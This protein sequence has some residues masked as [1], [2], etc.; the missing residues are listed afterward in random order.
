MA[1]P[2]H[3]NPLFSA[4]HLAKVYLGVVRRGGAARESAQARREHWRVVVKGSPRLL[5]EVAGLVRRRFLAKRRLP[6]V[7]GRPVTAK[8]PIFFQTE[9]TPNPDSR[10]ELA[11]KRDALGMRRL[12][13]RVAFDDLDVDTAVQFHRILASRVAAAGL[14]KFHHDGDIRNRLS[15]FIARFNSGSHHIGTTRMATSPDEGV[16]DSDCRVHDLANLYVAGSSVF[17]TSGH[18]NPTLTIVTLA[19]RLADHLKTVVGG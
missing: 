6:V 9:H 14:G 2:A 4:T 17:P 15:E 11:D 12:R 3:G 10:V 5:P 13:V 19:V 18:A 7:L 8:L 16:V 1:D